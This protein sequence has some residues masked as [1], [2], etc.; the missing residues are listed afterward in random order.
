MPMIKITECVT[1]GTT[2]DGL[3]D[4]RPHLEVR[5]SWSP[6]VQGGRTNRLDAPPASVTLNIHGR[7]EHP[8]DADALSVAPLRV[9]HMFERT[10]TKAAFL[11]PLDLRP[12]QATDLERFAGTTRWAFNWA[13]ALL[14]AHHQAYEGRRQQ[15]ARHL[16]GL[17]PEQ[18]DEL[19]VLANG[20]RDENGKKAKG[21]PVKR[22][23]YESIQKATKKA[24]S[25]ENKALGAEMKLWDEHRSLVVHKGRP[26]LTPGDEPAL[27]AP[28]LAHRLYARRVEL[29][30]IQKT[31]PDYYAEQRKKEREA[32][33]PNVVAMKRDLMAKG[34]Y[35]PSEY[36]LQYIWRTV[37]DLPKEEGGSPWWPECPTILFYDGINRARTA[38][39]N[40]MDSASGAR[41]GPPVGMPR[42]KSKYKAK[43]TFTITNPN[44]S[45]IKFETYRRI[46][47]TGIGSMRLHRGAK[48]LARRIA[49]GQA[50]ITS[51]TISRSGTA[52]Y[53][54]VLCTVHTTARTAPSKAQRSRGAVGVDWGVRALATTSKPI[55]L[56]PGKPASRTVP[57]EKYG[58]AMS[59]KI[60]RAQRQLARMPKGSSRR[61]KAARH[62]ADLQHLVAQRRASSVHQL[63]KALAQ[64]FEIVAIEGLNVRGMTKSAKGTVENPGK[65]IRQK[66]GLNRAILDATPG[67]LKRQLE[68]KTK[69][70]GS[71]L[72]ELDTWY[73]SSKTCS[74]CG[75]VHPKLKLSMRTFRCQ[76]C[77]LVEDR[78]FNAAV[79]I[80]R[81]GITHIV[82]ENEGTDDREEG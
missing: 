13:N 77:G 79:N 42:F 56:T 12:T 63:S 36:D 67:E 1:W 58:A 9:R 53:V 46:A 54:S 50:E 72:V 62:V 29:A 61:R 11:S 35:F 51:A 44:R 68:Y 47:I 25:E 64:S 45:V 80:E 3:W 52:W 27:D 66:A 59:Q 16:F 21:D 24:V 19:R 26:L 6:P 38:W 82:K 8:R 75:W 20:T 76:Q 57:A 10:T 43:D 70:Y 23:E 5:R 14:E 32:I 41:K 60:A 4:A 17:G 22:R 30:G 81:Q 34:A 69:K 48:L 2:C 40:W 74:R 37:R 78:D 65:N 31:D 28:P 7:V 15:A 55:A 39:K 18:L 73:P 49:A 71:R 33:T